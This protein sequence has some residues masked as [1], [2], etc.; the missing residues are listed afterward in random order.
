MAKKP[1]KTD[2]QDAAEDTVDNSALASDLRDAND[3]PSADALPETADD[4][5]DE[6]ASEDAPLKDVADADTDGDT[7]GD[8]SD[9]ET[10]GE[11]DDI[12]TSE[13]SDEIGAADDETPVEIEQA[14]P[15]VIKET[16]VEHKAGL[17]PT[18]IGGMIAAG[19]GIVGIQYYDST[20]A[21]D[22]ADRTAQ[23]EQMITA[24]GTQIEVL[25]GRLDSLP[26]V[27][28]S[29]IEAGVS[30]AQSQI[31]ALATQIGTI[32]AQ[33]AELA[34][35][36]VVE[37]GGEVTVDLSGINGQIAELSAALDA[38]KGELAQMIEAAQTEKADAEEIARQT[39]ARAAVTRILVALDSGSPFADA[40][41]DVEANSDVAL[42]EALAQT[43][44]EGV[45]TIAA[46]SA[47]YPD[48]AREALALS[49][50]E[51][52]ETG[53]GGFLSRQ[54]GVRS[55]APREGDDPDAILSRMEA[56]VK[57]GRLSDALAEMDGLPD[58]AKAPLAAWADA[59]RLRLTA[60]G[61]AEALATSLN[62]Q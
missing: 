43:A 53:V 11:G 54:L 32:E 28:T 36:P 62:S 38:Q 49:R 16:V 60:I 7:G 20:K 44:S 59:A 31:E 29:A 3:T 1:K 37:Q 10:S 41:A 22:S 55:V 24:Q 35:R 47:S 61:D 33:V 45:P 56:A 46:L 48:A 39:M 40:L 15:Q 13:Q 23:F 2:V 18:A 21:S 6:T 57:E 30:D 50:S 14:A 25:T 17:L 12:A 34:A 4:T 19:L 5:I 52:P 26:S 58:A 27:D 9:S 42:S 51:T 8:T